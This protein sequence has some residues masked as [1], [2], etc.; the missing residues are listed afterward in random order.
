[1]RFAPLVAVALASCAWIS[2]AEIDQARDFDGDGFESV[3]FGGEA[4]AQ[5]ANDQLRS[6]RAVQ[7]DIG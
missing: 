7:G 2:D 4:P 1:M 3:A 6:R 5:F